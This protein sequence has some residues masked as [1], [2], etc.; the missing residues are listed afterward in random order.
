MFGAHHVMVQIGD[1]LST[2]RGQVEVIRRLA[3]VHRYAV[4]KERRI[5]FDQISGR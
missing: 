5:F 4:P 1:P 3:E 2:A